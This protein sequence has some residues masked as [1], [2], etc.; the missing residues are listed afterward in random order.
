[1]LKVVIL[2]INLNMCTLVNMSPIPPFDGKDYLDEGIYHCTLSDI[3]NV[4]VDNFE[5]ES[6]VKRRSMFEKFKSLLN[7]IE[8]I[9][10]SGILWFDG[11]FV[12]TINNPGDIDCSLFVLSSHVDKLSKKGRKRYDTV[13]N[14]A[15][16]GLTKEKYST[17]LKID[18]IKADEEEAS[19]IVEQR[20]KLWSNY[21]P[22]TS[23]IR[24]R[25]LC[26]KGFLR[27][28]V[29]NNIDQYLK[30]VVCK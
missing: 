1:M 22:K 3:E 4:F 18:L 16:F 6:S 15:Y 8:L 28:Q 29:G 14:D 2:H 11:S 26:Q 12:T 23:G 5:F 25:T 13:H 19:F 20:Y 7:Q 27:L 24:I 9:P 17:D 30:E 21:A 10:I